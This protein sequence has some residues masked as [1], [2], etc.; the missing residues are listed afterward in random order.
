MTDPD[1][2]LA[3]FRRGL[4]RHGS[5]LKSWPAADRQT[6]ETLLRRRADA[7]L[8]F[9][10]AARLE[11][12]LGALTPIP[13]PAGLQTRVLDAVPPAGRAPLADWFAARRWRPALTAAL[14]I[15][16]GFALGVLQADLSVQAQADEQLATALDVLT[17]F[18]PFEEPTDAY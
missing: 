12:L 2:S 5:D 7:A 1:R 16:V 6:A 15:G 10:R 9:E 4:D 18:E 17:L 8:E 13:A 11:T 3:R 14:S